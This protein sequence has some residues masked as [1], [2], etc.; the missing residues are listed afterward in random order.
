M[1]LQDYLPDVNEANI[2]GGRPKIQSCV[3]GSLVGQ[4]LIVVSVRDPDTHRY[5]VNGESVQYTG[6]LI[7]ALKWRRGG[8]PHDMHGMIEAER[9]SRGR[10]PDSRRL[11]SRQLWDLATIRRSAHVVPTD[12]EDSSF[13]INNYIDWEMYNTLYRADW[14][15]IG[16]RQADKAAKMMAAER[17]ARRRQEQI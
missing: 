8:E 6:A 13:Y 16:T 15:T 3:E 7:D 17:E 10:W 5:D 2:Q 4:L 1:W 14:E 9:V 11:G 12:E